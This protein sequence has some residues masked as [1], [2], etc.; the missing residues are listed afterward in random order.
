M[1]ITFYL[2]SKLLPGV[3][4]HIIHPRQADDHFVM[5]VEA[6]ENKISTIEGML[7]QSGA[8]EIKC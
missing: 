5:T 6:D 2:R 8:V 3:E 4:P 1:V 7:K